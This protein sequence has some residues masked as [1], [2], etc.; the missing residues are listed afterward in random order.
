[1]DH[2]SLDGS[3]DVIVIGAGYSGLSA[4]RTLQARNLR[5]AVLEARDRVGGR[6]VERKIAGDQRLE[7][8]GQY[9]APSQM[10][11]T[12]LVQD[13]GLKVYPAH[14]TGDSF[15]SKG[16]LV[17]RYTSTPDRC[18]VEQLGQRAEVGSEIRAT[19][20]ELARLYPQVPAATP[21]IC[22]EAE[23]WDA[24]TFETWLNVRLR[25]PTAKDFFRFLTNQAYSTEPGQISLL[26]MLWFLQTT[27]G[28]PAWALGGAQANRVEGGT[29][30]VAQ[31][32]AE[33]LG[34]VIHLR[35][36]VR[37]IEQ[38]AAGV[39]V[40][41]A[42]GEFRARAA[43]VCLPPQ[44]DAGLAYSPPLPADMQRAF[45]AQLTGNSMKAQ[46]VYETPFWRESGL[47]GNG[48]H[49]DGPQTF[50][51]DNSPSGETP[52]VLL[53]FLSARRA[54]GWNRRAPEERRE[55]ILQAWARVFGPQAIS[56]IDYI[57][58]DWAAEPFTR[59]GHG[60]HF[61]PGTWCELGPALGGERMPNFGRLW[62]AAS[63]LAKDWNGYLEGALFAGQQAADEVASALNS[64][65]GLPLETQ[66]EAGGHALQ[67]DAAFV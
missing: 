17:A 66:V 5:V 6:T 29:G 39:R 41:T 16:S 9:F 33:S 15:L 44:L 8:G 10:R 45:S 57:E 55:A 35:Q 13:L 38:S 21:W 23:A 2:R 54:T 49:W 3:F 53:G 32:L 19:L 12:Q 30:L 65:T 61:P 48:I 34:D 58:M 27:H 11:V 42:D 67:P 28:L 14:S 62:W 51:F 60:C 20:E 26:Q 46:A 22:L 24:I 63:D 50:T 25:T 4:A 47:S 7:L 37:S 18:L 56:P 43:I 1:M 31:R 52:G 59:G 40:V 64:P 36:A